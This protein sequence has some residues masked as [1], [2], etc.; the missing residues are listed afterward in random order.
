VVAQPCATNADCAALGAICGSAGCTRIDYSGA[1]LAT[2]N[3]AGGLN[4]NIG[5]NAGT[6]DIT[7]YVCPDFTP[8]PGAGTGPID[9]NCNGDSTETGV[10]ADLTGEGANTEL[11]GF[12]D[13]PALFF[14]F[15]CSAGGLNEPPPPQAILSTEPS[16]ETLMKRHLLFPH[17]SVEIE[18][19]PGCAR[20]AI[21]PGQPGLVTAALLGAAGFD[22]AEVELS[23]LRFHGAAPVEIVVRDVKG[24]GRPDLLLAFDMARL[25][26]ARGSGKRTARLTGWLKNSQAFTGRQDVTLVS[27]SAAVGCW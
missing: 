21:A 14:A 20:K 10:T 22:V 17:R 9:W 6:N 18:I 5:I 8:V 13:W 15:H 1:A 2:L 12:N 26:L 24:D 16:I 7:T 25:N 11:L 19:R 3:E 4:E 27:S 23:S